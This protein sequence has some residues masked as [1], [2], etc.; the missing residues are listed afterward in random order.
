M[1]IGNKLQIFLKSLAKKA[2]TIKI[3]QP[4]ADIAQDT[5]P[6]KY[7]SLY[8]LTSYLLYISVV[9]NKH[10]P[11]DTLYLSQ[12]MHIFVKTLDRDYYIIEWWNAN[13]HQDPPPAYYIAD[14][15]M[16]IFIKTL[17]HDGMQIFVKTLDWAYY[18]AHWR[19]QIFVKTLDRAYYIADWRMQ[20]F[21]KTL[22]RAY[23]IADW[24]MQIFVKTLDRAYY[25][26][27]WQVQIFVKTLTHGRMQIFV[28]TLAHSGMQIFIK[29]LDRAHYIF[30]LRNTDLRQDTRPGLL[31]I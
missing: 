4:N 5:C 9:E 29:T 24:R 10:T 6:Y 12:S 14:W 31:C 19:M 23:Y 18:I 8:L 28:K 16:Q 25:I 27:D 20:I 17:A 26:A 30:E 2:I 3:G 21:V 7:S 22:D 13:L 11:E 1:K 15:R